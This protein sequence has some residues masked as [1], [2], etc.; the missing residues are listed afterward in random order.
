MDKINHIITIFVILSWIAIIFLYKDIMNI[1]K[2]MNCC[3]C[4][5]VYRYV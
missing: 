3:I 5:I 2:F 1:K 4:Y